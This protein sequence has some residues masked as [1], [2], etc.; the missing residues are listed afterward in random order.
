MTM[1]QMPLLHLQGYSNEDF[2]CDDAQRHPAHWGTRLLRS[3]HPLQVSGLA[4][5][6]G[7]SI[8][9]PSP[10]WQGLGG[11]RDKVTQGLS[12]PCSYCRRCYSVMVGRPPKWLCWVERWCRSWVWSSRDR[13][14]KSSKPYPRPWPGHRCHG[15]VLPS[16]F[17]HVK[18]GD[19]SSHASQ[20]GEGACAI[21]PLGG[22]VEL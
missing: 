13:K 20:N 5:R 11:Q 15:C 22:H 1:V 16:S 19:T 4:L 14:N 3:I 9:A 6:Q 7:A 17:L 21:M 18:P 10:T 12:C 8:E 2:E